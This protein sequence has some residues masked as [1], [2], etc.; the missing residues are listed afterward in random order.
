MTPLTKGVLR[1]GASVRL[2]KPRMKVEKSR[3]RRVGSEVEGHDEALFQA[4]RTL[5][6]RIAEEESVPVYV[7]FD[8]K[9]LMQMAA[10]KPK[11]LEELVR[12]PG[13]G[14]RKLARYGGRFLEAI[15]GGQEV[16]Q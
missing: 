13:V 5:R 4:L 10:R 7:V 15:H 16:P 9:T 8:D 3:R 1:E 12:V 11:T 14:E 6:R 2:A